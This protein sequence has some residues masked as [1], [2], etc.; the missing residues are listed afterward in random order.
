MC[1]INL[2]I[3][4]SGHDPSHIK[5]MMKATAHRGPDHSDWLDVGEGVMVAGNRLKILD[6]GDLPNQPITTPDGRG[7][8]VWNG[9]LYN[10]QD[11]RNI[12][13]DEGI[14]FQT[15]SDSEVLIHWLQ[16][17]G[18][19][20]VEKLEGMFAFAY[21]DKSKKEVIIAR[22]TSGKKPLYY[23]KNQNKW[24][25]SSETIGVM[26]SGIVQAALNHNQLMP[27]FYSR[28]TFPD[29]TLYEGI[30]QFK[31]GSVCSYSFLGE[32]LE[33]RSLEKSFVPIAM[34]TLE[35]FKELL[36]DAVLKHFHAEVPVGMVLSGGADSTLLLNTWYKE[37]GTPLHTF[38]ATF[39]NK[40]NSTYPDG[41]FAT[42]LAAKYHCAHHEILVTPQTVQENWADYIVS[43][44]Q[45]I[46]DSAGFLTW[47]IAKQA[48]QYVK[49]LISGAGADEL[50][51]GYN[52]HIAFQKYLKN[53]G[54][55]HS[56]GKVAR[57]VPLLPRSIR[58]FFDALEKD[59]CS[60]FLNFTALQPIP[61]PYKPL[62]LSYY[63]QTG[64]PFKDALEWDRSFYL[65][66][67]VLKIH[68]NA[69]MAHG[70][71][72][73]A[74]YLDGPL[75]DLSKRLSEEQ[76]LSLSPKEWIKT[77][78]KQQDLSPI[79]KRKKIGFGIPI[80]EWLKEDLNFRNKLLVTVKSFGKSHGKYFPEEMLF[81][82]KEPN[83]YIDSSY[84]QI[85]NLYVLASWVKHH[86][87]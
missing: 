45:P 29:A 70:L 78:L 68:D 14:Q 2:I 39:G 67:D 42:G 62:Y 47:L 12:L 59:V 31:A 44:D 8:L 76:H 13:L 33:E 60:S 74:P 20:G 34:P 26:A 64:K 84:L 1:G 73:R 65:I 23:A 11:L 54:L 9:A 48:K 51:G 37:T 35:Q 18:I 41:R 46:G 19:E 17:H 83:R 22:D 3:N 77:L 15:R 7:I 38:T 85:W 49:V 6:L 36:I 30:Y 69:S 55:Y 81:I 25:F 63:K 40:Y 16:Q 32:K 72:G 71:E 5:K 50:F 43:L 82:C 66:N 10:Y 52:R 24:V 53:P 80:K 86:K 79:A 56:M 57:W 75:V 58:K 28:H 21:V 87:L 27:Y 4:S 61:D